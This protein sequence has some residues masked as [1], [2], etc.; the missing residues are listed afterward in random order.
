MRKSKHSSP[1]CHLEKSLQMK[2]EANIKIREETLPEYTR[3]FLFE[4][5]IGKDFVRHTQKCFTMMEKISVK[6]QELQFLRRH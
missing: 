6:K 3:K 4:L 1:S 2:S 5:G